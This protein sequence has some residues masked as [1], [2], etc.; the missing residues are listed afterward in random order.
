MKLN[1]KWAAI[2]GAVLLSG[3]VV[4]SVAMASPGHGAGSAKPNQV[5][6]LVEQGKLTQ[7]EA[8]VLKQLQQLRRNHMEQLK[9]E[10]TALIDQAV[11]DGKLTQQQAERLSKL[12]RK[13]F[14]HGRKGELHFKLKGLTQEQ[15][16][17]KLD[18]LVAEGRISQEQAAKILEH[19]S[20][21]QTQQSK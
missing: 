17:A 15:L 20:Q 19:H 14:M 21:M 13:H 10:S 4:T 3:A 16:K 11:K 18:S 6:K 9:K 7:A 12:G 8:D 2:A 5:D 1:K